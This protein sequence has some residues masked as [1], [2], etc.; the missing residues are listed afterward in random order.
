MQKFLPHAIRFSYVGMYPVIR[1]TTAVEDWKG[2]I[3]FNGVSIRTDGTQSAWYPILYDIKK[4]LTYDK[5]T[6]DIEVNCS[7]CKVIY[8]NGSE[9]VEG[10]HAVVKS[11]QPKD[12][13]MFSGDFTAAAVNGTWFLNSGMTDD[14]LRSFEESIHRFKTYYES[15]LG[16]PYRGNAVY[17]QTS[18]VSKHNSWL[19][20]TYPTIVNIGFEENALKTFLDKKKGDGFKPYLAH[21]LAHYYFGAARRFNS[22]LGDMISEGFA[23]F[24]SLRITRNLISDSLFR[25]KLAAKF[26]SM[27]NFSPIPFAR[28][29]SQSDYL[30][31]ELYVYYYA[32]L[33]FVAIE[34]EIGEERMWE[35]TRSVLQTRA[36]FTDYQFLEKALNNVLKDEAMFNRIRSKYFSSDSVMANLASTLNLSLP[37]GSPS[38]SASPEQPVDTY[39]F[40]FSNPAVDAGS[41]ENRMVRHT[42]IGK[43]TG[44]RADVSKLAES[45]FPRLT[46]ACGNMGG[47][48]T[49]FNTYPSLELAKA[50]LQRWLKPY[51]GNPAFEIKPLDF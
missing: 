23:E 46:Q 13:T 21:E 5:V 35:W 24:L 12:L 32:P 28:V 51:V 17:V 25:A 4:D 50:G 41:P 3:A 48:S 16:I 29:R 2:N 27:S 1:D 40:F 36:V 26:R 14:Q 22:P 20:A 18:P 34:K 19:F 39:Y 47:C 31:R 6:Y 42:Q 7:D 49:N 38:A 33:I 44:T 11:A 15:H 37:G 30:D 45:T 10:T 9:P 43:I 8:V